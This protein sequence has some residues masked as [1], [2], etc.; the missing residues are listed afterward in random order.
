MKETIAESVV[1]LKDL[2]DCLVKD[3][4]PKNGAWLLDLN[5]ETLPL[6]FITKGP[7]D[8]HEYLIEWYYDEKDAAPK[9]SFYTSSD[10]FKKL[11]PS[12]NPNDCRSKIPWVP[13]YPDFV[14]KNYPNIYEN[15]L[16]RNSVLLLPKSITKR[17][18]ARIIKAL[19]AYI[20]H[21]K[22]SLRNDYK[23]SKEIL[24]MIVEKYA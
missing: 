6:G 18:T 3:G 1:D 8:R 24:D 4:Y 19:Y 14:D 16:F 5:D 22:P 10:L 15:H 23:N 17:P 7:D 9:R 2:V 11:R 13:V 20:L 12:Y 21:E